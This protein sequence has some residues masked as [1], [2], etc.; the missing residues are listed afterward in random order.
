MKRHGFIYEK[1]YDMDNLKEAHRNA[2]RGKR[3]YQEVKMVN[4]DPDYYLSQIQDM[5]KNQTYKVSNYTTKRIID[6]GKERVLHK[7]PYFPDR[8]IQ[9]AV[10]LQTS[11]IFVKTFTAFTCS[12][13]EGRGGK[14]ASNLVRKYLRRDDSTYCL[15]FDIKKYYPSVDHGILKTMLRKKFKDPKLLGLFDTIIDSFPGQTGIPIGSYTSQYFANY[16]L[17]YFD[18]WLKEQCKTQCFVRY[19][20]DV[21]VIHKSKKELH[22]LLDSITIYLRKHL[23]LLVKCNHQ[24]YNIDKR[25]IDFVGYRHFHKFTLLRKTICNR[26]KYM[27]TKISERIQNNKL[28]KHLWRVAQSYKGWVNNCDSARLQL[29]YHSPCCYMLRQFYY[30]EVKV[31]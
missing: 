5:L 24:V 15:K 16:Y 12:S 28:T 8:I 2:S 10:M 29:K 6:N 31:C 23:N 3:W 13:V 21:I 30:Q 7:L 1:I 25:G 18:H 20:D 11:P 22:Q 19:M 14:K 27:M 17:C 26:Y 9:W 4:S